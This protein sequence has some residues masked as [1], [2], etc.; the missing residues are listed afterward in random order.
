MTGRAPASGVYTDEGRRARTVLEVT[1]PKDPDDLFWPLLGWLAGRFSPDAVPFITGLEA[2]QPTRDDL[3][4]LCAAFGTTS[5]APMLHV[6]GHTPEAHLP[7]APDARHHRIGLADVAEAW[8]ELN[9]GQPAIDLVAIGSPHAS[10]SEARAIADM[11]GDRCCAPG[12]QMMVTMGRDVLRQAAAEGVTDRLSRA[13]V[14]VLPDLCWCSIVEP[15]FPPGARGLMTNSGKYAHYAHGLSGRH[16]RLGSLA[17][18]VEAAVGGRA[19]ENL[20]RWLGA[21]S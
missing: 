7:P 16:A 1:A 8:R 18:C 10:L 11:M 12:T 3:K 9:R 17:D 13:G 21:V 15:V 5:G 20:P 2:L 14:R 4:A 19:P 6:A